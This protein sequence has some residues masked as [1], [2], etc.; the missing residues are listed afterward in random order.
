M[1]HGMNGI[2]RYSG[3]LNTEK[4][5]V[6]NFHSFLL[7]KNSLSVAPKHKIQLKDIAVSNNTST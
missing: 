1:L 3:K 4:A 5:Q 2:T 6:R 7:A